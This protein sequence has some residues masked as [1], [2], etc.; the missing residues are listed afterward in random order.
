QGGSRKR[1]GSA[2]GRRRGRT[3][4]PPSE[5]TRS[6]RSSRLLLYREPSH[7]RELGNASEEMASGEWGKLELAAGPSVCEDSM[8]ARKAEHEGE[9]ERNRRV[10]NEISLT[11]R[12]ATLIDRCAL[13]FLLVTPA[14]M[15]TTS[16]TS[17]RDLQRALKSIEAD[18][19]RTNT[20]LVRISLILVL[21]AWAWQEYAGRTQPR[22]RRRGRAGDEAGGARVFVWAGA[23]M[24]V[25][26][27]ATRWYFVRARR[28]IDE[29]LLEDTADGRRGGRKGGKE[30]AKKDRR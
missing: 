24:A 12:R 21:A 29:R 28:T 13:V 10:A 5:R 6:P 17:R 25:L 8:S 15:A 7:L 22:S 27:L 1:K 30:K 18:E 26:K 16:T 9:E 2:R 23:A 11:S 19:R 3:P 20:W 4:V 14:R